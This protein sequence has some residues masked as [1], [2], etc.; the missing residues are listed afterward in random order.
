M[1]EGIA[2]GIGLYSIF[3]IVELQNEIK[4]LKG[5]MR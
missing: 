4:E 2:I 5:R 1:I 3:R